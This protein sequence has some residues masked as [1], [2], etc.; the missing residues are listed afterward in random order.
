MDKKYQVFV[1]STYK[2][3]EEERSE[4]IQVLLE[5]DC[6]PVGMELFPA[7][8]E[9]QS[10]FIK[11][12]IDECDYYIIILGGRYGSCDKDGIGYTEKEFLHAN[13]Q[14]IPILAFIH[15]K[16]E[17]IPGK[18]LEKDPVLQKKYEDFRK[19]LQDGRMVKYWTNK[20]ALGVIVSRSITNSKKTHPRTGWVK[21]DKVVDE[22]TFAEM[23]KLKNKIEELENQ[24]EKS[25]DT[26]PEN[27]ENLAQGEDLF[28]INYSHYEDMKSSIEL[29]WNQIFSICSPHMI[30]SAFEDD[31][32]SFLKSYIYNK[33]KVSNIY[34]NNEDF[35]TIIIQLKVLGLTEF[36][37]K[38]IN[39]AVYPL[40]RLTPYGMTYMTKLKAIK[41]SETA[42]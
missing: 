29:S 1:S 18:K 20:E 2:D 17:D 32:Q 34:I 12:I 4:V 9:E 41:K 16:P 31:L 14:N 39:N 25:A 8:D 21:A 6:I 19:T 10:A 11:G 23:L 13:E 22:N 35:K 42:V 15:E 3:L 5:S 33:N 28:T 24:I 7:S 40:W 36:E 27:T 30:T 38:E 26:P 37:S